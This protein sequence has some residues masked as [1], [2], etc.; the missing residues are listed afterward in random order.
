[1]AS[2]KQ[3]FMT[4][5]SSP[6]ENFNKFC[7]SQSLELI[8]LYSPNGFIIP[9]KNPGTQIFLNSEFVTIFSGGM[10]TV[11]FFLIDNKSFIDEKEQC[12]YDCKLVALET[13]T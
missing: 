12:V 8:S 7:H 5:F 3:M 6:P 11:F 10:S 2:P 4:L 1:M 9:N 13:N